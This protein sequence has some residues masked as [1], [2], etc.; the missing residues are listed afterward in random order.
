MISS[1]CDRQTSPEE[2]LRDGQGESLPSMM[3]TLATPETP[4]S[5]IVFADSTQTTT[6]SDGISMTLLHTC[7]Q[8]TLDLGSGCRTCERQLLASDLRLYDTSDDSYSKARTELKHRVKQRELD[9]GGRD[10]KAAKT[11]V[12]KHQTLWAKLRTFSL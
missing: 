5:P 7:T 6:H 10:V 12:P 1:Y 2:D 11:V 3:L 8:Q 9:T 4:T